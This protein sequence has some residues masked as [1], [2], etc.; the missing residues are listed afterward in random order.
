[1]FPLLR[2]PSSPGIKA[3]ALMDFGHGLPVAVVGWV[4]VFGSVLVSLTTEASVSLDNTPNLLGR[5]SLLK[6]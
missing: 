6:S 4:W 1:M 5:S 2:I 3:I